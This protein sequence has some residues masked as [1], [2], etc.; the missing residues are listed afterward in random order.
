MDK[1]QQVAK[2]VIPVTVVASPSNVTGLKVPVGTKPSGPLVDGRIY[3]FADNLRSVGD[4]SVPLFHELFHLGLRRVI[5]AE[6]YAVLLKDLIPEA[7]VANNGAWISP[8]ELPQVIE[9]F[10]G[11]FSQQSL[12]VVLDSTV[13]AL[14]GAG[15]DD[16]I[17]GAVHR[18]RIHLFL[19]QIPNRPGAIQTL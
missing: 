11:Q 1:I 5:P 18:G 13:G 9:G 3:L 8:G 2:N 19:D 15:N 16:T 7:G 6:E 4:V 12:V 17:S 10:V 14:P